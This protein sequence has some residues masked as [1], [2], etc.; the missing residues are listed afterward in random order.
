MRT[1]AVRRGDRYVING[2]KCFITNGS[3]ADFMV[4]YAYTDPAAGSRGLSAFIVEKGF[5]G[6]CYGKDENKMGMRGSVNSTLILE[7]LEVPAANLLGQEGQGLANLLTTLGL[8]RLFC[9]A[10]AVGI[11]QGAFEHCLRYAGQRV[12]FGAPL[13]ALSPIQFMIADM[14][15]GLEAA[16]HLTWEAA[17]LYDQGLTRTGPDHRRPGQGVRL[18]PG[19]EHHHRRGAASRRLRLH[20]G[21]SGGAHDARRQAHPDIHRHQPD[22]APGGRARPV[23][24]LKGNPDGL[25]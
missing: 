22:N 21:L 23:G 7:N 4:L 25:H 19:H 3:V 2:G 24:R 12:Q 11:A 6:L 16:R 17:R 8:S 18:G 15:A 9:A 1:R 20:E 13:S 5:P 10:Q 14:A